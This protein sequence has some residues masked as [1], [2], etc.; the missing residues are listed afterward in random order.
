MKKKMLSAIIA[1]VMC[2][3]SAAWAAPDGSDYIKIAENFLSYRDADQ[4][5][6]SVTPLVKRDDVIGY[7]MNLDKGGYIVVPVSR[8]LSPVKSYSLTDSF[9]TLPEPYKIFLTNKLSAFRER[10]LSRTDSAGNAHYGWAFL[11]S[12]NGERASSRYT[13]DTFLLTAQWSQSSPYN[14]KLPKIGD[15]YVLTGC[16]QTAI[17][18]LMKYHKH[19]AT[20]TGVVTHNWNNQDL[21]AILYKTYYWDNMP[22]VV[23][24]NEPEYKQDEVA[25]LMRD[26]GIADEASFGLSGT[27][28]SPNINALMQNFGYSVD[29]GTMQNDDKDLFF[30]TLKE[31]IDN[32]RPVLLN[33]PGHATVADGYASDATGKTFHVNMGWGG[34]SDDFYYLDDTVVADPY[35]FEPDLQIIYNVKPCQGSDCYSEVSKPESTDGG[36]EDDKITGTFDSADDADIYEAELKGTTTL[37]GSRGYSNQAFYIMIYK[38]N[39]ELVASSNE[40]V[41]VELTAGKYFIKI[42][43]KNERGYAYSYDANT[44]YIVDIS[45]Q[46]PTSDEI[47]ATDISPVINNDFKDLVITSPEIIRIDAADEDGDELALS[48]ESSSSAIIATLD[49]YI[50]TLT[51]NTDEGAAE[52]TVTA[53]ANGK[54][55]QKSFTVIAYSEEI[56]FGK[57]FVINDIFESQT[58]FNKHKAILDGSC[59]VTGYNGY[60]NQAFFTAILDKDEAYL[61]DMDTKK[62]EYD[63]TQDLYLL[64]ASLQNSGSSYPYSIGKGDQYSLTV[65]CSNYV[66]I[67][68]ISE[69]LGIDTSPPEPTAPVVTGLSDDT[70]PAESKTWTWDA[71]AES[72][73]VTFRYSIDQNETWDN[74]S[75]DYSDVRTA[76]KTDETGGTWYIHVQAKDAD[77]LE[78]EVVTVSAV[79]LGA[80]PTAPVVTGL[81]DD[82]TP[83][84]SKTWTW[85]ATAESTPVTF[86]YNIDQNETWDSPSGD[87]SDIRTAGKAEVETDG[88]WYIHV[89]AKDADSLESEVVT[90]SAILLGTVRPDN[91][92]FADASLLTESP[93]TASNTDATKETD[94]PDHA[95]SKGGQSVWWAWT[96]SESAYFSFDTKGSSFDTLL[97]VYTGSGIET[98][99]EAASNNDADAPSEA[100]G[101]TEGHDHTSSLTLYAEEGTTYYIAIDGYGMTSGDITLN[102]EKASPANDNM[103]DAAGLSGYSGSVTA[104]NAGASKEAVEPSHAGNSGGKSLWWTWTAPEAVSSGYFSFDTH[105]SDFDTLIAVY[106]GAAVDNLVE[107]EYND[108]DTSENNN[109]SLHFLAQA[110]VR[111]Y[112]A[113]DGYDGASGNISLNWRELTPSTNDNFADAVELPQTSRLAIASNTDASK[114]SGDGEPDHAGNRGGKSV[115]WIG[116]APESTFFAFDTSGSDFDTLLAVYTG[117]GVDDLTVVAY[118]DDNSN[119][120]TSGMTF[121]AEKDVS[122][123]IVVDG[124]EG[125]SGNII[126]NWKFAYPPE[127]DNFANAAS[128]TEDSGQI[129]GVENSEATKEIGEPNHADNTGGKS[130]WWTWTASE[131]G[132]FAFDTNGSN[133]DTIMAVY[134]GSSLD[135]LIKVAGNDDLT[136]EEYSGVNFEAEAGTQYYIAVDGYAGR[137]GNI[138]LNWKKV[139]DPPENDNFDNA[140][141][142]TGISEG[143]ASGSNLYATREAGEPEHG[144]TDIYSDRYGHTS[145]WWKWTAPETSYFAFTVLGDGPEKGFYKLMGIYTG[146][147]VTALTEVATNNSKVYRNYATFLAE[148]GQQYYI[149]VDGY[150]GGAG[151]IFLGWEKSPVGDLNGDGN[152]NLADIILGLKVSCGADYSPSNIVLDSEVTGD[153]IIGMDDVLYLLKTLS[154]GSD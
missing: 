106:T 2:V 129:T 148:S 93:A 42:S 154:L 87:Y 72:T 80:E 76:G 143:Q 152:L 49:G 98:L 1:G 114:E 54:Q 149:A 12:Y 147:D 133:F 74:P 89:Q 140:T 85:D 28:A 150:R 94:E 53:K 58:D 78:S 36:L 84:E 23:G 113:V 101:E 43:L 115:W 118:S 153:S 31:E 82:T 17:G 38:T 57:E 109:S 66:D 16:V 100:G 88:T 33:F 18:Q 111:Y 14:K 108:N 120:G 139:T 86:R 8:T 61:T 29:I 63:A 52:I 9:E 30:S 107:T 79:L 81:S 77:G 10:D 117:S 70:T 131:A 122:Y 55:V 132:S 130:V 64:G 34:H 110:G 3:I 146:S 99:T 46:T 116:Q 144:K 44:D 92:D 37:S 56:Y 11:L 102:W 73:P 48:V 40:A 32:D 91:D 138:T 22:D 68:V 26:L 151:G 119:D 67:S 27:S 59:S 95:G 141:E 21:K 112:I 51:P 13:A 145:V 142:L 62:I 41:T 71:T 128:L 121:Y 135:A 45:T 127:N 50:L 6:V 39:N 103:A 35:T 136:F 83:A 125:A 47:A 105:G 90:V 7:V 15:E 19:P 137:F 4:K 5:I 104:S 134:T 69:L 124:H 60:S 25:L 96:A 97:A 20:G 24:S 65:I 75:G 123:Y 126:L